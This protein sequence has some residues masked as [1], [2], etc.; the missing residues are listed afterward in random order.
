M[1]TPETLEKSVNGIRATCV[2][3]VSGMYSQDP[4]THPFEAFNDQKVPVNAA[5]MATETMRNNS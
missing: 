1:R 3:K 4:D 5:P 2:A